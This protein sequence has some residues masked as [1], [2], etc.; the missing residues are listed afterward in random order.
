MGEPTLG[1][2]TRAGARARHGCQ[3][4]QRPRV[5]AWRRWPRRPQGSEQ[6]RVGC[7]SIM[8]HVGL[9]EVARGESRHKREF[10]GHDGCGNDARESPGVVARG[11]RVSTS[12]TK[13]LETSVLGR[14]ECSAADGTNLNARHRDGDKEVLA[15]VDAAERGGRRGVTDGGKEARRIRERLTTP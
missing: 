13:H 8:R 2:N 3:K 5:R 15:I 7:R 10:T 12:D 9:D 4:A 11:V 1:E 14:E 6:G